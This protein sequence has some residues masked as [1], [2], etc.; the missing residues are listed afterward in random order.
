VVGHR[1]NSNHVGPQWATSR[2]AHAIYPWIH[3]DAAFAQVQSAYADAHTTT[4]VTHDDLTKQDFLGCQ[5][6]LL[7]FW[8]DFVKSRKC[9]FFLDREDFLV[10][11]GSLAPLRGSRR[12]YIL[13]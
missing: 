2:L 5:K 10:E 9:M 12:I 6:S 8:I 3:A 1:W 13:D 4:V 7:F 11:A